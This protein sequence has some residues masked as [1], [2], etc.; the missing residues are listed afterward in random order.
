M[1]NI[2]HKILSHHPK[3]LSL[4]IKIVNYHSTAFFLMLTWSPFAPLPAVETKAVGPNSLWIHLIFEIRMNEWDLEYIRINFAKLTLASISTLLMALW[5]KY[6]GYNITFI[7]VDTLKWL[8]HFKNDL[9]NVLGTC[10]ENTSHLYCF[11]NGKLL[12]KFFLKEWF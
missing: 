8:S 3:W 4:C 7:L 9:K 2:S 11:I 1:L 12:F 10:F 6:T 5:A